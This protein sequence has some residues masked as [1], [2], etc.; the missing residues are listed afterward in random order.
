VQH[1]TQNQLSHLGCTKFSKNEQQLWCK[2]MVYVICEIF[3][4]AKFF[5]IWQ[6]TNVWGNLKV[7][8]SLGYS[9]L[10]IELLGM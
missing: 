8:T 9:S 1:P 4:W 10:W 6:P 5:K 2:F 3:A 7:T